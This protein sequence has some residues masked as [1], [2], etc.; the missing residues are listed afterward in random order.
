MRKYFLLFSITFLMAQN[1]SLNF[2]GEGNYIELPSSP[3]QSEFSA[4]TI[5]TWLKIDEPGVLFVNYDGSGE[6]KGFLKRG[7]GTLKREFGTDESNGH[8]LEYKP[9]LKE[10]N[11][12]YTLTF[13]F[14]FSFRF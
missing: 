4:F 2:D 14:L 8:R 1:Y 7:F 6:L 11:M 10:V 9:R 5:S 13:A 3:F 12:K